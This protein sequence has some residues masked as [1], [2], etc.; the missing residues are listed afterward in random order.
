MRIGFTEPTLRGLDELGGVCLVVTTFT[1]DRPLRGLAGQVDWRLNG[2]LSRLIIDQFVDAHYQEATLTPLRGQLPFQRLLFVGLGQRGAYGRERFA[3][4]CR[5]CFRTLAK[6]GV[7]DFAM[8]MPGHVGLD[9]GLRPAL[10]GWREAIV[11]SFSADQVVDLHIRILEPAEVERELAEPMRAIANELHEFASS[12]RD[13][14]AAADRQAAS[15][16]DRQAANMAESHVSTA[17]S[18]AQRIAGAAPP[19]PAE[20]PSGRRRGWQTGVVRLGGPVSAVLDD[21]GAPR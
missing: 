10:A 19:T 17:R 18:G 20:P 1:D 7:T 2:R 15:R 3:D 8:A 12:E 16:A 13:A 11:D 9:I 4:T 21:D 14:R 6:M 5:F